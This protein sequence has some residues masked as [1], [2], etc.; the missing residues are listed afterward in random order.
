MRWFRKR[1][2]FEE[3]EHELRANR[4]EPPEELVRSISA[5]LAG[6]APRRAPLLRSRVLVAAALSAA[7]VVVAGLLGGL[8]YAATA[9]THTASA[10]SHIFAPTKVHISSTA[11]KVGS[12]VKNNNNR[13]GG[14]DPDGDGDDNPSHHQYIHFVFVCLHVPPRH[15]FIN[16]TLRLPQVAADNLISHGLATAGPCA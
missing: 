7:L 12:G 8:S 13:R 9:T 2:G 4:P 11:F 15:P 1:T 6:Q 14:D 16:I 10:V 3:L 5:R